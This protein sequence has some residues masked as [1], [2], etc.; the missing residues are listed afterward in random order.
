MLDYLS[1]GQAI[2]EFLDDYPHVSRKQAAGYLA[3]SV[4]ATTAWIDP[5]P[6][7]RAQA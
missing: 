3:E 5:E 1:R 6:A 2:D 4:A 7:L